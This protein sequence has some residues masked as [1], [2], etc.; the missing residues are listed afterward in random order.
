MLIGEVEK[1]EKALKKIKPE[2]FDTLDEYKTEL[3]NLREKLKKAKEEES[4]ILT[5]EKI[6]TMLLTN[7][8]WLLAGLL[9]I[10]NKQTLD[11]KDKQE[12]KETNGIGF[13]GMDSKILSS[14]AEGYIKYKKLTEKQ[15]NVVRKLLPKY[16]GQLLKIANKQ[17]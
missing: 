17:I 4:H 6:Q 8:K 3:N 11:E 5:K 12:T 16:S 9:A 2:M 1:L 7:D 13:N 14:L 10:Y 15:K